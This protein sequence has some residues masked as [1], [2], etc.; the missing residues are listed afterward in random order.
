MKYCRCSDTAP[1]DHITLLFVIFILS[2]LILS[3]C[4]NITSNNYE[5]HTTE[6]KTQWITIG[7]QQ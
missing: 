5:N 7:G 3:L 6:N 1:T 4:T 2:G